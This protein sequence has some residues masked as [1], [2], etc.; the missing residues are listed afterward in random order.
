[1]SVGEACGLLII[2]DEVLE[3]EYILALLSRSSLEFSDVS[4]AFSMEMAQNIL[5]NR[6]ID[7]ML[8]DIEMPR[9]SGLDL[10][11]WV[12]EQGLSPEVIITTCHPNFTYAQT[13]LQRFLR[14]V[15]L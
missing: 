6:R 13:A 5:Q 14:C 11:K 4:V 7:I 15:G 2:D 3:T 1:M 8:C 10:L 12:R 9:G